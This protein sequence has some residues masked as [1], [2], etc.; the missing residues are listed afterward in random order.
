MSAIL[1]TS[2]PVGSEVFASISLLLIALLVLLVLRYFLPLRTTP[3][4]LLVPIFFALG[5]PASIVLL[6]PIDLASSAGTEDGSTRG[7]WLPER[8]L[9]VSWRIDYWLTFALTWFILPI[10]AEYSDAGYRDPKGRILHSLR[11]NARYQALLYGAGFLGLIYVFIQSG[12]S[13]NSL[14]GLV[15]AL[16]YCWALVLA[17]YLMGHGLV[18]IPRRLI[19]D[20]SISGRLRKLQCLAPKVHERMEDAIATLEDLESDVA[21]LNQRK[22][23][24]AMFFKDWIEDLADASNLPE[25]RLQPASLSRRMGAPGSGT[26]PNVITERYLADLSRRVTRARH[27]RVRFIDEWDQ[28]LLEYEKIDKILNS[29]ASKQLEFGQSAPNAPL[30]ERLTLL[31]PYTRY[32]YYYYVIPY[33]MKLLGG[34][35]TLASFCI[36]WSEF[37]KVLPEKISSKLAIVQLTVV[38]HPSSDRGE[39]GFAGQ[40]IASFWILYMCTC[41]CMSLT[42]VKVWRGRALVRRNTAYE[43]AFWYS[44]QVAKLSVPLSYNFLTFLS[45][46]VYTQTTFYHFLG[47]L[48]NLTPLGEKF[49]FFFPMFILVPVCATLFNLYGKV[50]RLVGLGVI[51]DDEEDEEN[52]TGYGIGGWREGRDLIDRELTGQQS[53]GHLREGGAERSRIA[54]PLAT[55]STNRAAPR[56]STLPAAKP[57]L[58][59][60]PVGSSS[61]QQATTSQAP[62]DKNFFEG[63][64]H[65]MKNTIDTFD[66]PAW[67]TKR[68]K[69]MGG[70]DDGESS[71]GGGDNG[72]I[73]SLFG[74]SQARDVG[75]L[76]L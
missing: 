20:A 43:S 3:A 58:R 73:L 10:L 75:R 36:V 28:L 40:V 68:P 16:A 45:P 63:L 7:I 48:I 4:Y 2:S 6:V 46:N 65:R 15:M 17:I 62:E 12:A 76:R 50:K 54:A 1:T 34:F 9:L 33:T 71:S 39:I 26:V 32:L 42:E 8:L 67:L 14:K 61:S 31:T 38:H 21:E 30:L 19:K 70:D 23:G 59:E 11:E 25:S 64:S 27:S 69:W 57:L 66:P 22:S 18:A 13:L 41:A 29:A 52:P 5:L 53:L 37:V 55:P 47:R 49:D 60:P 72:D 74:A 24:S 35:L 44:M 56:S 51:D